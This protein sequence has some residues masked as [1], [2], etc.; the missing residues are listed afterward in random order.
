R[1]DVFLH[2]GDELNPMRR[3]NIS[4]DPMLG[5]NRQ[6]EQSV[7]ASAAAEATIRQATVNQN[8]LRVQNQNVR[9]AEFLSA[10][11]GKEIDSTPQAIWDWWS[12]WNEMEIQKARR[13]ARDVIGHNVPRYVGISVETRE[14]TR[15]TRSNSGEF[16]RR[17]TPWRSPIGRRFGGSARRGATDCLVQGTEVMTIRGLQAIQTILP[18]DLVLTRNIESGDLSWQPVADATER[19][20]EAIFSIKTVDGVYQSTGGHMHWVSGQGWTKAREVKVGDLLHSAKEPT[21]VTEV[22]QLA[23]QATHN[24]RVVG[25]PNF[26]VGEELVLTHD[27]TPKEATRRIVPGLQL[28]GR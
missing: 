12:K 6:V 16:G 8:N 18:G 27:V 25:N 22:T 3:Q 1:N 17:G 10:V 4:A 2:E 9:I 5:L 20:P 28:V 11:T 14:P 19:P 21:V 24:L 23:P 7:A 26:F 15:L 13:F